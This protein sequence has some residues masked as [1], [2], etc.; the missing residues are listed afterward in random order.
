MFRVTDWVRD[1]GLIALILG[2]F[3]LINLLGASV[4]RGDTVE[5]DRPDIDQWF[6]PA[7]IAP[8]GR[9]LG[10]TFGALG[11]VRDDGNGGPNFIGPPVPGSGRDPSRRGTVAVGFDTQT[12]GIP[13]GLRGYQYKVN[14]IVASFTTAPGNGRIKYDPT[15]DN[16]AD[17]INNT[18][19]TG[20][21]IELWGLG[22]QNDYER[23]GFGGNDGVAPAFEEGTSQFAG[24]SPTYHIFPVDEFGNDVYNSPAGGYSA[25]AAENM[26]EA[27]NPLPFAVGQIDSLEPGDE[28]EYYTT[29]EFPLDLSRSG[30]QDYLGQG[31]AE[32]G[33]GFM[34]SSLH[35]PDAH[36]G[37]V[38]YPQ[39][40]MKESPDPNSVPATLMLDYSIL[41]IGDFD[42][43][44]ELDSPDIDA[45]TRAMLDNTYDV[46][47]DLD[48]N[49]V[50][51]QEDRRIW[52]EDLKET[53]FG[54]A[55]LDQVVYFSDFNIWNGNKFTDDYRWGSGN[56]NGDE[57]VDT[58]DFNSWNANKFQSNTDAVPEPDGMPWAFVAILLLIV[59]RSR[60][61]K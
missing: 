42:G 2:L 33:L 45:I 20:Q 37:T 12:M 39:W 10:P 14:S 26:T 25:T 46:D 7:A 53:F 16:P 41:E 11:D 50:I 40:H 43:S 9:I 34:F 54:D 59:R 13:V 48:G 30:V 44:G 36:T 31:L 15:H 4:A 3:G 28:I 49:G 6:Y 32:G 1:L 23:L 8:G 17:V 58:S 35:L 22:F 52:V 19:D 56:F 27:W 38:I 60:S 47:L 29:L 57:V 51:D 5:W 61:E 18:D 55:N 24:D 21:S